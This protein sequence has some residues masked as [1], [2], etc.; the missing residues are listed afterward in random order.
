[1]AYALSK[2]DTVALKYDRVNGDNNQ[3]VVAVAYTRGF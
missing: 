3:K 2:V 1:L